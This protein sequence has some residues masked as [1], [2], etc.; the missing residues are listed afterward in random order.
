LKPEKLEIASALSGP[1]LKYYQG[2]T[3]SSA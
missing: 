2:E 1:E 3:I